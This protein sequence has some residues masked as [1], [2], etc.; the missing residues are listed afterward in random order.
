MFKTMGSVQKKI[1]RAI[2]NDHKEEGRNH[3]EAP[4]RYPS[5]VEPLLETGLQDPM[6]RELHVCTSALLPDGHNGCMCLTF[7]PRAPWRRALC[8]LHLCI[9][10]PAVL[11]QTLS[12]DEISMT[13]QQKK[14][15]SS[16]WGS[17]CHFK[18]ILA[19]TSDLSW[20][21]S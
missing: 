9:P 13:L 11:T 18:N 4:V 21:G 7:R 3:P 17:K 2:T 5:S 12:T 8:L 19:S 1:Q 6:R 14:K 16:V 10:R 15:E 20:L